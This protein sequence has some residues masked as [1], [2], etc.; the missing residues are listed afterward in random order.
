[1]RDFHIKFEREVGVPGETV[2]PTVCKLRQRLI[3]E[4]AAEA[5]MALSA[6]NLPDIAKE[7]ADL[8]YVTLGTA[9]SYGIDLE[10]IWAEVHKSNMAKLPVTDDMGKVLKPDDWVSPEAKIKSI[11]K[12]QAKEA[13]NG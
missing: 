7:L 9:V 8:I 11:L 3:L 4:E 2:S 10:P 1:M 12:K 13:S 6:D 5:V